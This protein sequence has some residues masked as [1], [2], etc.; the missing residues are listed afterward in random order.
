GEEVG[1]SQT[2]TSTVQ[3]PEKMNPVLFAALSLLA[4]VNPLVFM[5]LALA[6]LVGAFYLIRKKGN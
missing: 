3:V 5:V 2:G 1:A 4:V 6:S